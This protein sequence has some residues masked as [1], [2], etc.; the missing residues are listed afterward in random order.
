M[1]RRTELKHF[2]RN[3]RGA[4]SVMRRIPSDVLV[5]I[6]LRCLDPSAPL[7]PPYRGGTLESIVQ[8]CGRWRTIAMESPQLWRHFVIRGNPSNFAPLT[9]EIRLQLG[10]SRQIPICITLYT[11]EPY[12]D[13]YPTDILDLFLRVSARWQDIRL[14]LSHAH[15]MHL[16]ASTCDFPVLKR[17]TLIC[18]DQLDWS[19]GDVVHFFSALPALEE[20]YLDMRFPFS[21]LELP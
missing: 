20:L 14:S 12:E 7:G 18:R 3:H 11:R 9:R 6:F 19:A 2:V 21:H 5:E 15:Y 1:G 10:R 13:T 8:V 16:F 4:V 17:L